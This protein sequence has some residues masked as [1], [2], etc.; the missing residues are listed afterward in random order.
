MTKPD[1]LRKLKA[2]K[3]ATRLNDAREELMNLRFQQS[4]GE[5]TD[6]NRMK[7]MRREIARIIT[8]LKETEQ[9]ADLEVEE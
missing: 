4:S 3:L 6:H 8:I 5:L 1:E 2:D 9:S 7:I